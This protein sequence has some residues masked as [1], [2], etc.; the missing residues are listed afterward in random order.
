MITPYRLAI[1]GSPGTGKSTLAKEF[2]ALGFH[3]TSVEELA[4]EYGCIGEI[5]SIDKARPIDMELLNQKIE[6]EWDKDL[7]EPLIIDGHLSHQLPTD[8]VVVLR[9]SPNILKERMTKRD[10]SNDKI[11]ANCEW[12][13]LG[14]SWNEKED[15]VP[16]IEYDTTSNDV[17]SIVMALSLWISDGFKPDAP[18][19]VID[20]ISEM[21]D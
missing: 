14:S 16:W 13:L 10:Y 12:E 17:H 11:T 20:W 6:K 3:V 15:G 5:D 2:E 4:T 19:S 21:E 8:A 18:S 7:L 1:T 9:C